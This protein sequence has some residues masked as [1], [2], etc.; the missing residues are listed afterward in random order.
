MKVVTRQTE[1]KPYFGTDVHDAIIEYQNTVCEQE[2]HEIYESYIKSAF[3][4]LSENLIFIYGFSRDQ[5]HF[6]VLKWLKLTT[7]G[8]SQP[9][10]LL[11]P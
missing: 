6:Y 9:F 4:K 8:P 1:N 5:D 3:E 2:K 11:N 10:Y 7:R